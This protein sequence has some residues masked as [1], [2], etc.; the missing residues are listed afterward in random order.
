MYHEQVMQ[1]HVALAHLEELTGG[2]LP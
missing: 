1:L 2:S